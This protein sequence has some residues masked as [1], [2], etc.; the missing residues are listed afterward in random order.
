MKTI[1]KISLLSILALLFSA[2]G[3]ADSPLTST[4]FYKAYL[5]VPIVKAAAD[6][7]NVLTEEMMAYLYNDDNPLDVRLA[8]INAVGW[9]VEVERL[10]TFPD[11]MTYCT[12]H[13]PKDKKRSSELG[14]VT[15]YDVYDNASSSQWAVMIYLCAMADYSK[16]TMAYSLLEKATP[17]QVSSESFMLPIALVWAQIKLDLG[18]WEFIYPSFQ[19]LFGNAKVKDMRPEARKIIYEYIDLYKEYAE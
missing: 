18:Q 2:K 19:H 15:W 3:Y 14:I 1:T 7:P 13:F 8:L 9:S 16:M 17:K 12:N 4:E 10:S 11:Y 5:D 6:K